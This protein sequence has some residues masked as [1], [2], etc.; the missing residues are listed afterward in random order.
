MDPLAS[1]NSD[2]MTAFHEVMSKAYSDIPDYDT[3][4]TTLVNDEVKRRQVFDSMLKAYPGDQVDYVTWQDN[5]GLKKKVGFTDGS[6][7]LENSV[8]SGGE[9]PS[10]SVPNSGAPQ[11]FSSTQENLN[12]AAPAAQIE[13][14]QK[15]V[16]E[17]NNPEAGPHQFVKP[18]VSKPETSEEPLIKHYFTTDPNITQVGLYP[19]PETLTKH[20]VKQLE[21]LDESQLA[22]NIEQYKEKQQEIFAEQERMAGHWQWLYDQNLKQR[23]PEQYDQVVEERDKQTRL[24]EISNRFAE[25]EKLVYSKP[26]EIPAMGADGVTFEDQALVDE[27][28]SLI[29]EWNELAGYFREKYPQTEEVGGV[30]LEYST[31][32]RVNA[33]NE[34]L[35]PKRDRLDEINKQIDELSNNLNYDYLKSP[36]E[37][38]T[39]TE[40]QLIN[41]QL[42]ELT[43]ER[44][45]LSDYLDEMEKELWLIQN[46]IPGSEKWKLNTPLAVSYGNAVLQGLSSAV[47]GTVE[48]AIMLHGMTV[49]DEVIGILNESGTSPHEWVLYKLNQAQDWA[50]ET[51]QTNPMYSGELGHQVANGAG[52]I[53]AFIA[54]G[55][56]GQAMRLPAWVTSTS[57]GALSVGSHEYQVAYD[58][59]QDANRMDM[60]SWVKKYASEPEDVVKLVQQYKDL[61]ERDPYDVGMDSFLVSAPWGA[62]EG[63]VIGRFFGR[64]NKATGGQVAEKMANGFA[65]KFKNVFNNAGNYMLGSGVKFGFEEGVQEMITE[66]GT[67]WANGELYDKT[68][69]VFE[70]V[71]MAGEVGG[72][73]GF[74]LGAMLPVVKKRYGGKLSQEELIDV[75][76]A[77]SYINEQLSRLEGIDDLE[78]FNPIEYSSEAKLIQEEIVRIEADLA[79]GGI[80]AN[81]QGILETQLEELN[82]ELAVQINEDME[83]Q[84]EIDKLRLRGGVIAEILTDMTNAYN[85]GKLSPESAEALSGNIEELTAELESINQQLES[86]A[87]GVGEETQE[88][89]QEEVSGQQETTEPVRVRD[90]EQVEVADQITGLAQKIMAGETEFTA[91]ELQLQQNNPQLL[92]QELN[93]LKDEGQLETRETGVPVQ[94]EGQTGQIQAEEEVQPAQAV[95]GVVL[96]PYVTDDGRYTVTPTEQGV[97]II[98]NKTK[99]VIDPRSANYKT[100]LDFYKRSNIEALREGGRVKPEPGMT[101]DQYRSSVLETSTNPQE[102]AEEYLRALAEPPDATHIDD[103]LV[104]HLSAITPDSF[105]QWGDKN[106]VTPQIRNNYFKTKKKGGVPLDVIAQEIVEEYA[107]P[108]MDEQAVI[109]A[110]IDFV[111][112]NPGGT[113]SYKPV[114]EAARSLAGKFQDVAGF[115]I[116]EDF[117]RDLAGVDEQAS[118][119]SDQVADIIASEGI[120]KDNWAQLRDELFYLSDEEIALIDTHYG[121]QEQTQVQP[122]AVTEEGAGRVEGEPTLKPTPGRVEAS[123]EIEAVVEDFVSKNPKKP[124]GN[125]LFSD[126]VKLN[127]P[128]IDADATQAYYDSVTEMQNK[129]EQARAEVR[130]NLQNR[131]D[132]VFSIL[133]AKVDESANT[134]KQQAKDNVTEAS[135]PVLDAVKAA[136]KG[137]AYASSALNKFQD[138]TFGKAVDAAEDFVAKKIKQA[139]AS[140]NKA[141]VG[142]SQALS[143]YFGGMPYTKADLKNKLQFNGQ[144][145]FSKVQAEKMMKEMW[146]MVEGSPQ[147]LIKIHKLL[148]PEVYEVRGLEAGEMPTLD[149]L[150]TNERRLYETITEINAYVHY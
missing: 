4:V 98:N 100:V 11:Y 48:G 126:F 23:D 7:L 22:Q 60:D 132:S 99:N 2:K 59:T 82:T 121:T 29:G 112:D 6:S 137:V 125:T 47:L 74:T 28:N 128:Q 135:I 141:A 130:D 69:D 40:V 101:E 43:K 103:I 58:M 46:P 72:I 143:I 95:E 87:E 73:L 63:I 138:A 18:I 129:E 149:D 147:S 81:T 148:D 94:V 41:L 88:K 27:W 91:E 65:D 131:R 32:A 134:A 35:Q 45:D 24:M 107:P 36:D 139:N 123:P 133:Q 42:E 8:I 25:L 150:T 80:D 97:Q 50:N 53:A 51:W 64:L 142:V 61:H 116:D 90:V 21:N 9:T 31:E 16:W 78:V 119:L 124:Y 54:G 114:S 26:S 15:E 38:Y 75:K 52:Q 104:D 89:G 102:I 34:F 92:E 122:E 111:V 55:W 113:Q 145:N 118:Q 117:A 127:Y 13:Q 77:E 12:N 83:S 84:R 106:Y 20:Q 56:A 1:V 33:W 85:A 10:I 17:E 76:V 109:E 70:N 115:K 19:E 3:F 110:M 49:P 37:R 57:M 96:K 105:Y 144:V 5:L 30:E 140:H 136:R 67:N 62:L 66:I 108:G 39:D 79:K 44:G 71:G 146:A 14:L 93:R 120:T 68:R 86:Y